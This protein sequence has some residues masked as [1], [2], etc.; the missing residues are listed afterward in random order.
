MIS[1]LEPEFTELLI[2]GVLNMHQRLTIKEGLDKYYTS[3]AHTL[4]NT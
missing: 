2:R 3:Y 1:E 4:I